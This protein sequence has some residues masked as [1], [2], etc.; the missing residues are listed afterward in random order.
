MRS[1]LKKLL[2]LYSHIFGNKVLLL[3]CHISFR[4]YNSGLVYKNVYTRKFLIEAFIQIA[5]Q[6]FTCIYCLV[7]ACIIICENRFVSLLSF[8]RIV[9]K[10]FISSRLYVVQFVLIQIFSWKN[11]SKSVLFLSSGHV[12]SIK[13]K[14]YRHIR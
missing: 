8:Q 4:L 6:W 13:K 2:F 11:M 5:I 12:R 1:V 7:K 3:F 9:P 10:R 14:L